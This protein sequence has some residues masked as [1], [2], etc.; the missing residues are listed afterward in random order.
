MI[1]Y[2]QSISLEGD[3]RLFFP[4]YRTEWCVPIFITVRCL[5]SAVWSVGT[6]TRVL[7]YGPVWQGLTCHT[8]N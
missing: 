2:W 6:P 4:K 1:A 5:L 7:R 8:T 3:I